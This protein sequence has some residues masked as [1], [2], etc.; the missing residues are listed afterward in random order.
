LGHISKIISRSTNFY[1]E[2]IHLIEN[3]RY[4]NRFFRTFQKLTQGSL[5]RN[6]SVLP[7]IFRFF[8]LFSEP[9]RFLQNAMGREDFNFPGTNQL[10]KIFG[11]EP[12]L[13]HAHNLHSDFF[14][15]RKL[16]YYSN[17][18]PFFITL[19]DCW[20]FTGHCCHFFDCDKWKKSCG[21][22]PD[23]NI[24]ISLKRDGTK[25]NLHLKRKVYS[26]SQ[27]HI[28]TPSNWLARQVE[29]S[30]LRPAVK[31]LTVIPNGVDQKVFAPA[32]KNEVRKTLNI[33]NSEFVISFSC[34]SPSQNPWKNYKLV[35]QV[36][37]IIV[38]SNKI[39]N[40]TFLIMGEDG[41]STVEKHVSLKKLGWLQDKN[42]VASVYQA[43]D[44]YLHATKA[45]TYP[46]AIL[47]AM[48][49]GTPVIASDIGGIPEQISDQ[50]DGMILPNQ[51]Q[52]FASAISEVILDEHK[53]NRFARNSLK[54]ARKYFNEI[55]MI[56]NYHDWYLQGISDF[57]QTE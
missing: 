15:L 52:I 8:T 34:N 1:S 11:H 31:S 21:K 9:I 53:L 25:P 10:S 43:S 49:C 40:I 20:P 56:S 12:D 41:N 37:Q 17:K 48:S 26:N 30:V 29:H 14:D 23:I 38:N 50:V 57:A 24:P 28:A 54:K 3:D 2:N 42:D 6:Y 18:Y 46:N 47:E 45:D 32:N 5:D 51:P 35:E 4:R 33:P 22:C 16:P 7:N 55:D 36:M 44:L 27:I 13:I 19:H 39:R